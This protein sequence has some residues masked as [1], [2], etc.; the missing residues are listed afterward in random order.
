MLDKYVQNRDDCESGVLGKE[1]LGIFLNITADGGGREEAG[2]DALDEG[3]IRKLKILNSIQ[4]YREETNPSR[5]DSSSTADKSNTLTSVGKTKISRKTGHQEL[6]HHS[7][8]SSEQDLTHYMSAADQFAVEGE[9]RMFSNCVE[10][11]AETLRKRTDEVTNKTKETRSDSAKED[12]PSSGEEDQAEDESINIKD[13]QIQQVPTE[14]IHYT[15][16][17]V[18]MRPKTTGRVYLASKSANA[19]PILEFPRI[20]DEDYQYMAGMSRW[21]GDQFSA[22]GVSSEPI[23]EQA[24]SPGAYESAKATARLYQHPCCSAGVN[25]VLDPWLRVKGVRGLRVADASAWEEIPS[26]HLAAPT[27]AL[28]YLCAK[29]MLHDA[30]AAEDQTTNLFGS[31]R[32]DREVPT[33]QPPKTNTDSGDSEVPHLLRSLVEAAMADN[34]GE[35]DM[36][37]LK[38]YLNLLFHG[39]RSVVDLRRQEEVDDHVRLREEVLQ[40]VADAILAVHKLVLEAMKARDWTLKIPFLTGAAL[41]ELVMQTYL[42]RAF[43]LSFGVD[44]KQKIETHVNQMLAW[45]RPRMG[46]DF[47]NRRLEEEIQAVI[48]NHIEDAGGAFDGVDETI[49]GSRKMDLETSSTASCPIPA[50]D[51]MHRY[52]KKVLE[53][54]TQDFER[55]PLVGTEAEKSNEQVPAHGGT[56]TSGPGEDMSSQAEAEEESVSSSAVSISENEPRY[57]QSPTRD[58]LAFMAETVPGEDSVVEASSLPQ[59]AFGTGTMDER[60]FLDT[61]VSFLRKGGRVLDTAHMYDNYEQIRECIRDSQI[62]REQIVLITKVMPL[63]RKEAQKHVEAAVEGLA[64]EENYLYKKIFPLD[65]VLVHWPG[66][67]EGR[68]LQIRVPADCAMVE[69]G[70]TAE[71]QNIEEEERALAKTGDQPGIPPRPFSGPRT[72]QNAVQSSPGE[73]LTPSVVQT[74]AWQRCREETY[75]VLIEYQQRGLI[76]KIGFSNFGLDHVNQFSERFPANPAQMHQ[77]EINPAYADYPVIETHAAQAAYYESIGQ[78]WNK[79]VIMGYGMLGGNNRGQLNLKHVEQIARRN[80]MDRFAMLTKWIAESL[81]GVVT[82]ASR[83]TS[84]LEQALCTWKTYPTPIVVS[85]ATYLTQVASNYF[86]KAYTP[87]PDEIL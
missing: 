64:T 40:R 44:E 47:R 63:G 58:I 18:Q 50:L 1:R 19:R 23:T 34:V 84:R 4:T 72:R 49:K 7:S 46:L 26:S 56:S 5:D 74:D 81:R 22:S 79:C 82:V 77:M 86:R 85:D 59:I 12:E 15:V 53:K 13:V 70:K 67:S 9:I 21:M 31:T 62:P 28:G 11:D 16:E 33:E 41:V 42:R 68:K 27:M 43:E 66:N 37:Q 38:A 73:S 45:L 17:F 3:D 69:V 48:H 8:I 29:W 39:R 30:A 75:Q 61:C 14:Q 76:K 57:M 10:A 25:R 54:L 51:V 60:F 71:Q 78:P 6:E 32:G 65:Y 52:E 83:D 55:L 20:F 80:S 2:D 24:F 36:Q 35:S 87:Y